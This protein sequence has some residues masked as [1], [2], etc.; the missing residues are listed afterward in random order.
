M[1]H[2]HGTGAGGEGAQHAG[3]VS[4][5]NPQGG[6]AGGRKEVGGAADS[7]RHPP[8]VTE[9]AQDAPLQRKGRGAEIPTTPPNASG[10]DAVPADEQDQA[11][12]PESAYDDRPAEDKDRGAGK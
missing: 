10:H 6:P 5:E 4:T 7:G 1:N 11:I 8:H 12:R 9:N 2:Q 3:T